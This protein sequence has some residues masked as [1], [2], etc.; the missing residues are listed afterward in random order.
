MSG[1]IVLTRK[2]T[3]LALLAPPLALF[4]LFF[5]APLLILLWISIHGPSSSELYGNDL[6]VANYITVLTDDFYQTIILR[7]LSSGLVILLLCLVLGYATAYVIAPMPPRKRLWMMLLLILPLLV[8]NVVRIYGWLA[9]LGR[10]GLINTTLKAIGYEG[11]PLLLLNSFEAV[12]FGLMTILLPYMVISIA[13]SLSAIEQHYKEAAQSLRAS[14]IKT[15][16]HVIWPL[17]SPGVA[18]GMLLVF[19]L[20][21]SAYVTITLLGGPRMKLLVSLIFDAAGSFRWPLTAAI[22]FVLLALALI[23]A[24]LIVLL[25]RPRRVQGRG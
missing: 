19:L 18:S 11:R 6:T 3:G 24:G 13:N 8:S 2:L 15:F 16:I 17:S 10:Q 25:L 21:L 9:I 5:V 20:S 1:R 22:S 12:A 14:P 23:V 4:L 7:T